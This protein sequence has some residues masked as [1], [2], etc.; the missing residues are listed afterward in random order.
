MLGTAG[1]GKSLLTSKIQ[2]YY[3][4]NGAF[5]ATLNLDPG[6]VW[7][8]YAPDVDIREHVKIS[9][10]M[11]RYNLGPNGSL[12]MASDMIA[13]RLPHVQEQIHKLNPDYLLVDTPGQVE[14]FAYRSSGPFITAELA[15]DNRVA[16][17]LHDGAMVSNAASFLSV[18][19]LGLSIRL[20]LRIPFIDILSKVDMVQ[21][22][23][24]ILGWAEDTN[25]ALDEVADITDGEMY[26]LLSQLT[27]S[28]DEMDY[29]GGLIPVS[30]ATGSG[31]PELVAALGRILSQG[32]EVED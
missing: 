20:R 15:A 18:S 27:R 2:E 3:T 11:E 28:V 10:I 21:D 26:S 5:A 31:L 14:L 1:A 17:F 22:T 19:L 32:E 16:V 30:S 9:D 29:V 6:V 4:R 7:L 25:G 24:H 13:T 12:V 23:D 8:P